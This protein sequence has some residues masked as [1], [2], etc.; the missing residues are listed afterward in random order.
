MH[1]A[2]SRGGPGVVYEMKQGMIDRGADIGWMSQYPY[3][4]EVSS[5][6]GL[7]LSLDLGLLVLTV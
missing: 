5:G 1:Y 3:E 6:L 4:S 7:G 2:A